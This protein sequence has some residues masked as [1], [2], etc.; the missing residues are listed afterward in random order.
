MLSFDRASHWSFLALAQKR[1]CIPLIFCLK[2]SS[3]FTLLSSFPILTSLVL[4]IMT[5]PFLVTTDADI[6]PDVGCSFLNTS[7]NQC[8]R[9][10]MTRTGIRGTAIPRIMIRKPDLRA[11]LH[12]RGC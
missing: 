8:P 10:I 6:E 4:E 12:I 1:G 5:E 9:L 11:V 3:P 2:R 7:P